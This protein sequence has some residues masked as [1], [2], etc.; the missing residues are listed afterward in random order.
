MQRAR[1]MRQLESDF[2]ELPKLAALMA[3]PLEEMDEIRCQIRL[4]GLHKGVGSV[5]S[6]RSCTA[7]FRIVMNKRR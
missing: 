3:D 6:G 4:L 5:C 7:G 1:L 2:D